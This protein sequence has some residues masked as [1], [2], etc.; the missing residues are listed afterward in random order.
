[1]LC[2]QLESRVLPSPDRQGMRAQHVNKPAGPNR[3][4]TLG[5]HL[6]RTHTHNAAG[7]SHPQST[8]VV[9]GPSVSKQG[10]SVVHQPSRWL[11]RGKR[12]AVPWRLMPDA[13]QA[14]PCSA[15]T[16]LYTQH[17]QQAT[18]PLAPFA[19]DTC[20]SAYCWM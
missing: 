8:R 6:G 2:T 1:M 12:Y 14:H 5:G 9:R 13:S 15:K 19:Q 11:L 4:S 16:V 17:S 7:R 18:Q 10:L 20:Q 3:L